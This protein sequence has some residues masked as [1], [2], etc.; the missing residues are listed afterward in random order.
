MGRI[1]DEDDTF[2]E[3]VTGSFTWGELTVEQ[4]GPAPDSPNLPDR[5][6]D[7][8]VEGFGAMGEVRRVRDR[9]LDAVVAMKIIRT[10]ARAVEAVRARFEA[11]ARLTARLRHPNII[12]VF[13]HGVL[14]DGRLWFTMEF[15]QGETLE[16]LIARLHEARGSHAWRATPDGW[17]LRDL[18]RVVLSVCD[19]VALAHS[20]GVVHRDLKPANIM[21]G[22][23]REVKVMDWGIA[24]SARAARGTDPASGGP[25][26]GG[27]RTA[28]GKVIGTPVY[29]SPEQARG[30]R[31]KL[32]PW[33]DVYALGI[34]LYEVLVGRAPLAG[35]GD[36]V[37]LQ[38]RTGAFVPLETVFRETPQLLPHG[39][40]A[41]VDA[42]CQ[43]RVEDRLPD[44]GAMAQMLREWLEAD[45]R[46]GQGELLLQEAEGLRATLSRLE[47][48][49]TALESAAAAALGVLDAGAPVAAKSPGWQLEALALE[50]RR[51]WGET[52]AEMEEILWSALNFAPDH[53]RVR[54]ALADLQA[55]AVA[56]A[57]LAHDLAELEARLGVLRSL[58]TSRHAEILSGTGALCMVTDPPGA[59]VRLMRLEEQDRVLVPVF[60]RDLGVTPLRDV[61][62][63]AGSWLLE[64]SKPGY[65][66]VRYPV[67]IERG[68]RWGGVPPGATEP[69]PVRLPLDGEIGAGEVYVPAGWYLAGGDGPGAHPRRRL[70]V[71]GFVIERLPMRGRDFVTFWD[72]TLREAEGAEA[73]HRAAGRVWSPEQAALLIDGRPRP[74][75]LLSAVADG[76]EVALA[77]E[78]VVWR[79]GQDG[80]PWRLPDQHEWEKACRGVDGRPWPWGWTFDVSLAHV[81]GSEPAPTARA[82]GAYP[83]DVSIYGVQDL[84]GG[85]LD[86][87]ASA[88]ASPPPPA[89]TR[90]EPEVG[91]VGVARVQ[92]G[93]GVLLPPPWNRAS[94]RHRLPAYGPG[95]TLRL[96]R[97][98]PGGAP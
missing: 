79:R 92:R 55:E 12:G 34:L 73:L 21:I 35:T 81:I 25:V 67:F 13:D 88:W 62:V 93:G 14:D 95:G 83:T 6:E 54:E 43:P 23:H 94:A 76:F 96:V 39:L 82:A 27:H 72:Q 74:D 36:Q 75:A 87:T 65:H 5:Y 37:L 47:S 71:D 15:V 70:W 60:A 38:A 56:Q 28:L 59:R 51:T 46:R 29:M 91:R 16:A 8:G 7:V 9:F 89:G 30:E 80:Q 53:V 33:S 48:E 32:G 63:G 2:E 77:R 4:V 68:G 42:A 1:G 45:E 64:I 26:S 52:R 49:A 85:V 78:V 84:V 24:K 90:V 66:A 86:L 50:K 69:E 57:E 41:I 17:T 3:T 58:R 11:E 98:W 20:M 22:E 19:G 18:I 40:E 61:E 10:H 31:E 44:A 97:S